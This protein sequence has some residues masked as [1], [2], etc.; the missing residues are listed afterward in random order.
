[1]LVADVNQREKINEISFA[2]QQQGQGLDWVSHLLSLLATLV[3]RC[4]VDQGEDEGKLVSVLLVRG[5]EQ[6]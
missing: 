1:M 3:C 2:G 5:Y 4:R 6:A